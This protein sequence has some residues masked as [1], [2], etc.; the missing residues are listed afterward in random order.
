MDV[1]EGEIHV[2]S[3]TSW[4]MGANWMRGGAALKARLC[5]ESSFLYV[6]GFLSKER[7]VAV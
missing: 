3:E 5:S 6:G 1:A 4:E 2:N 7:Q